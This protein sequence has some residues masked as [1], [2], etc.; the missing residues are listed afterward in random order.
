MQVK[1]LKRLFGRLGDKYEAAGAVKP[2]DDMRKI[3]QVLTAHEEKSV[4]DFVEEAKKLVDG[5]P[6]EAERTALNEAVVREAVR[7]LLA[8]GSDRE[9][10]DAALAEIDA[11]TPGKLELYAIANRYR[12]EPSGGTHELKF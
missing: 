12:N 3:A 10:F 8:A 9:Q 5:R 11:S 1:W 4:A 2:A 6:S 7:Q